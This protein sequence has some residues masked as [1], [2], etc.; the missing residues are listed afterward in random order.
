[1]ELSYTEDLIVDQVNQN[2]CLQTRLIMKKAKPLFPTDIWPFQKAPARK[3]TKNNRRKREITTD[4]YYVFLLIV[5]L[6]INWNKKNEW[7]K[8]NHQKPK[9]FHKKK[10]NVP[11]V[12]KK[13][14]LSTNHMEEDEC[15]CLV[16]MFRTHALEKNIVIIV[17][18]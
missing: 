4:Y 12:H 8:L 9:S 5:Q 14:K 15:F 16:S 6:K 17:L 1:V 2:N 10:T 13:R 3:T 7:G 11:K 18:H